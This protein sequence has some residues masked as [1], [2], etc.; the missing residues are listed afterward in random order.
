VSAQSQGL[1]VSTLSEAPRVK[2]R[3]GSIFVCSVY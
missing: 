1:Q 3:G 2:F